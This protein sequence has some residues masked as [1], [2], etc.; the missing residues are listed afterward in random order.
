MDILT[1]PEYAKCRGIGQNPVRQSVKLGRTPLGVLAVI[2]T[3]GG[4]ALMLVLDAKNLPIGRRAGKKGG[5]PN[6]K[7]MRAKYL[8]TIRKEGRSKGYSTV[9]PKSE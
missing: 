3:F 9:F 8:E 7:E 2:Y 1:I 6:F 5:N 4:V